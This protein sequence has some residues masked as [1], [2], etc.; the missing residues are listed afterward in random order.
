M[1]EELINEMA[2][3]KEIYYNW[4]G[5]D[6]LYKSQWCN[7][8]TQL[9]RFFLMRRTLKGMFYRVAFWTEKILR[10]NKLVAKRIRKIQ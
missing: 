2:R 4:Y 9:Y 5:Y 6:R 7:E 10:A 1:I 8:H 3:R